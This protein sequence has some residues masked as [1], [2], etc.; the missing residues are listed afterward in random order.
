MSS[1]YRPLNRYYFV[2][3]TDKYLV[4]RNENKNE[5]NGLYIDMQGL[6]DTVHLFESQIFDEL[7]ENVWLCL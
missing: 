6:Q 4:H 1:Y 7:N 2:S 3:C 5:E